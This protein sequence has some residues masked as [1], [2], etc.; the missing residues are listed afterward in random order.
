MKSNIRFT[1]IKRDMIIYPSYP[2]DFR[3]PWLIAAVFAKH[4]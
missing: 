3:K 1:E 2:Q 4:T